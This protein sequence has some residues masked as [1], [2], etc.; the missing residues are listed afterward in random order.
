M[1]EELVTFGIS[2]LLGLGCLGAAGWV[3][4]NPETLDVDKIFSI[5]VCLLLA[6][7]FLG[8]SAWM[9]V[10]TRLRELWQSEPS[11]AASKPQESPA[12]KEGAAPEEAKKSAS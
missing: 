1:L 6:M 8:I 12:K 4:H 9:L 7:I 2:A 11:A 5:I 3:A 10:G